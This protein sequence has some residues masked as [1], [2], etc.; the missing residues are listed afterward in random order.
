[1]GQDWSGYS[2]SKNW[3]K[4]RKCDHL[5]NTNNKLHHSDDHFVSDCK[6]L[7]IIFYVS[8]SSLTV[9]PGQDR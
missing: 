1:M 8:V 5:H 6:S 7:S 3:V 2:G 4:W 9:H